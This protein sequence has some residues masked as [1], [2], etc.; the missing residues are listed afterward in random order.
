MPSKPLF[1]MPVVVGTSDAVMAIRS[2]FSDCACAAAEA[3]ASRLAVIVA[4]AAKRLMFMISPIS[5]K[6]AW[7][8]LRTSIAARSP[9]LTRLKQMLVT[10]M[11]MPG[12]TATMGWV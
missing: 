4:Y 1:G 12:S 3:V 8:Q 10:K 11:Q 6:L 7:R 2:T 5:E 9:S